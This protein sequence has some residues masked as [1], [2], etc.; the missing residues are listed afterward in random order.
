MHSE[1]F[2]I[3]INSIRIHTIRV[4]STRR[5]DGFFFF[6]YCLFNAYKKKNEFLQMVGV[7][8]EKDSS[9][10]C[11]L[12]I[13]QFVEARD[14]QVCGCKSVLFFRLITVKR[15]TRKINT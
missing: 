9:V 1:N 6:Y 12:Q 10:G 14:V 11:A 13:R 5:F 8:S 2:A 7:V 3:T 15:L 4:I